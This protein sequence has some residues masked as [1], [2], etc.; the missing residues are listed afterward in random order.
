MFV[1]Q[2]PTAER[3]KDVRALVLDND[4]GSYAAI[5]HHLQGAAY[6]TIT[7]TSIQ[8]AREVLRAH[9]VDVVV[10]DLSLTDG[11][12]LAFCHELREWLGDLIVIVFLCKNST[13]L[14]RAAGIELGADDFIAKPYDAEEL[15]M[16]I[17]LRQRARLDMS[18]Q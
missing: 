8:Q 7:A 10:L 12:G 3:G 13:G 17:E 14:A 2:G 16:R 9:N 1:E 6:E 5:V 18:G 11:S 15:L 4:P